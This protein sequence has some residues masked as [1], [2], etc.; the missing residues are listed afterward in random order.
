MNVLLLSLGQTFESPWWVTFKQAQELGGSV[1]K[2]EK[3]SLVTFWKFSDRKT[4]SKDESD[5][6]RGDTSDTVEDRRAPLLRTYHVFNLEQTEGI[7]HPPS[8]EFQPRDHERLALCEAVVDAMPRRPTIQ[9][10]PR[11][12]FYS[13]ALDTVSIPDLSRFESAESYYVTLF[14]E[15]AHSTGHPTR[16]ARPALGTPAAFGTPD[17]GKEELVA[18]FGAALLA[19]HVGI[20]PTVAGNQA[21]YIDG[22]LSVLKRDKRLLPVAAAQAQRAVDFIL[23]N[24]PETDSRVNPGTP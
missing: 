14:H 21:A 20:F 15:L 11:R 4:D 23:G 1:R 5:S 17:Y 6:K 16:L 22:W 13:P 19:G 10:D 8:Q 2:G 18:E 7:D 9:A 3:S 24:S 12:A